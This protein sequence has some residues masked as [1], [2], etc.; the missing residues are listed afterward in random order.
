M[1]RGTY[2]HNIDD[3]GRTSIPA[4]FRESLSANY[5]DRL[6]VTKHLL[7]PCL[8]AY[9]FPEWVALED[10]VRQKPK[11]DESIS[12]IRRFY[13]GSAVEVPIDRLGRIVLP[14]HLREHAGIKG[15]VIWVGQVDR[16]ELWAKEQW[17]KQS[18][19]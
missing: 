13:I 8:D 17:E 4:K 1:F 10:K 12:H 15:E 7:D 11:F 9:P 18:L 14:H 5:D 16:I 6:I 19:A 2:A 3:K